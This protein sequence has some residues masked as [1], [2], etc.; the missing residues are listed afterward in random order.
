MKHTDTELDA[1]AFDAGFEFV[2]LGDEW[3]WRAK[4]EVVESL[5]GFP[6]K[7]E[8]WENLRETYPN[9]ED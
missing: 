7:Q 6:N 8:A 5:H 2:D 1:L 4:F 3:G 9:I